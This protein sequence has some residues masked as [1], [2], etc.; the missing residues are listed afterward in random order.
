[1]SPAIWFLVYALAVYRLAELIS[2]DLIFEAIRR[3]V[4]KKAA[5]G[6][7]VWKAVA[8]W[9][10]CPLCIGVWFAL[11]AAFWYGSGILQLTNL[12]Y[13]VPLWLGMAG[14]QYFLS[15]RAQDRDYN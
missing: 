15:S 2:K 8:D 1:M 11:P 6:G 5:V 3:R 7:A 9:I 10:H 12:I 4:A 14:F 13:I